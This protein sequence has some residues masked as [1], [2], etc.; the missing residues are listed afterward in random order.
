MLPINGMIC[1]A[2]CRQNSLTTFCFCF[3]DRCTSTGAVGHVV[4]GKSRDHR[5]AD[6]TSPTST[7]H[8]SESARCRAECRH[9]AAC[10]HRSAAAYR[11]GSVAAV[12]VRPCRVRRASARRCSVVRRPFCI[13]RH[14]RTPLSLGRTRRQPD[15][16][17]PG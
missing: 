17:R 6:T 15:R 10:R 13:H 11:H 7:R 1:D 16:V 9:A 4:R 3:P 14:R 12:R 8:R 5:F 2:A